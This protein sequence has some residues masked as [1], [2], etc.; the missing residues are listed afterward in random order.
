MNLLFLGYIGNPNSISSYSGISIAG[1]N[2]Q[3][4]FLESLHDLHEFESIDAIS[5]PPISAYPIEKRI[6]VSKKSFSLNDKVNVSEVG[7]INL[8]IIKQ[9][10][11][12]YNSYNL[13]RRYLKNNPSTLIVQFNVFPQTGLP[14]YLVSKFFKNNIVTI[15]ADVP[16]NDNPNLR[17]FS[18]ML[19]KFFDD[20]T[21]RFIKHFK[22]YIVLNKNVISKYTYNKNN[23]I[24]PGGI[25][26]IMK[27]FP[28]EQAIRRNVLYSGALT[29]YSGVINFI[30]SYEY[31]DSSD[32]TFDIYGD[33]YLNNE[34]IK[35]IDNEPR[36]HFWGKLSHNEILELQNK[37]WILINPRPV[38]DPISQFTFPSKI[39]EYLLSG[40]PVLTTKLNGFDENLLNNVFYIDDNTPQEIAKEINRIYRLNPKIL[41]EKARI[42]QDFVVLNYKWEIQSKKIIEYLKEII[43]SDR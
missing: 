23:L 3:V 39:F 33:G 31:L 17:G 37:A 36:I 27:K 20:L 43:N 38:D 7:F 22:N 42:A 19:R 4:N 15:L 21:L 6:L 9:L 35:L 40:T 30:K 1:Q 41:T 25:K 28:L 32:I 24:I 18:F 26:D 2:Y 34:I 8:P 14:L 5:I 10:N 11:Q 16:L 13:T 12:V 29:E